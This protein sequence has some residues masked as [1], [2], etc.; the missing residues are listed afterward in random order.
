M[1]SSL[2]GEGA[3]VKFSPHNFLPGVLSNEPISTNHSPDTGAPSYECNNAGA[4]TDPSSIRVRTAVQVD[5][6]T[7]EQI[8]VTTL[9]P[10]YNPVT[11]TAS[12]ASRGHVYAAGNVQSGHELNERDQLERDQLPEESVVWNGPPSGGR[13]AGKGVATSGS[14]NSANSP[15]NNGDGGPGSSASDSS[16]LS[17]RVRRSGRIRW[18][19]TCR[20]SA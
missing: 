8:P 17:R 3:P 5:P 1:D 4:D 19:D 2:N 15:N 10:L 14:W 6:E 18:L 13:T 16:S 9:I 11:G 20:K 12:D 7:G